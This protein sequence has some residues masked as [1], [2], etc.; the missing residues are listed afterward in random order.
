MSCATLCSSLFPL[1]F[2]SSLALAMYNLAARR[3]RYL[4]TWPTCSTDAPLPVGTFRFGTRTTCLTTAYTSRCGVPPA[5][6]SILSTEQAEPSCRPGP[7]CPTKKAPRRKRGF[8]LEDEDQ[9]CLNSRPHRCMG[10]K[11]PQP[12]GARARYGLGRLA[13]RG[14]PLSPPLPATRPGEPPAH[15]R[16][17]GKLAMADIFPGTLI[18]A[19]TLGIW[20][21]IA[22]VL[23]ERIG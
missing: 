9:K 14:G 13:D 12:H 8:S 19:T 23:I 21:G 10:K 22:W 2:R 16:A 7:E 11:K 4:W 17:G 15:L 5:P 6:E 3:M 18:L 20:A 1:S